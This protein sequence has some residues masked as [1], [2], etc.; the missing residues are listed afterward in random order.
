M[1]GGPENIDCF[2]LDDLLAGEQPSLTAQRIGRTIRGMAEL[3]DGA[4][5]LVA[6]TTFEA[7]ERLALQQG[8]VSFEYRPDGNPDYPVIIMRLGPAIVTYVH[9]RNTSFGTPRA[10]NYDGTVSAEEV[11]KS[12]KRRFNGLDSEVRVYDRQ[13][14]VEWE[15]LV[16]IPVLRRTSIA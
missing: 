4:T 3:A 7:F 16:R 9:E 2:S 13:I 1:A 5:G 8:G 10:K 15:K 6:S 14:E 11:F 12:K